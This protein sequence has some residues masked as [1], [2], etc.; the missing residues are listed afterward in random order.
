M[1]VTRNH[2]VLDLTFSVEGELT[3]YTQIL[4]SEGAVL[5]TQETEPTEEK[6]GSTSMEGE[7]RKKIIGGQKCARYSITKIL[8]FGGV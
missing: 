2:T 8:N 7:A 3:K 1:T 5:W 4:R 6:P